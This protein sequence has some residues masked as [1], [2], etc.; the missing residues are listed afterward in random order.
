MSFSSILAFKQT[1]GTAFV[2]G[3]KLAEALRQVN[4]QHIKEKIWIWGPY[5]ICRVP[6]K[7]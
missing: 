7:K 3:A 2:S 1:K 4:R 5:K 6:N